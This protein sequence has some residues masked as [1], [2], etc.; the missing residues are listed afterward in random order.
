MSVAE[1][2]SQFEEDHTHYHG[3]DKALDHISVRDALEAFLKEISPVG[4]EKVKLSESLG[5]VLSEDLR[6][7]FDIPVFDRST[8]DGYALKIKKDQI[9]SGFKFRVAGE[10]RIGKRA[11][12]Q[13]KEGEAVRVATGSF[14]PLGANAVVMKEYAEV[15]EN[16]LA[17]EV[18][19]EVSLGE[20]I[21]QA[22]ED[23]RK[24]SLVLSQETRI[25]PHHVALLALVGKQKVSV[26]RCPRI[27]FFSTGD[28][29]VDIN[30]STKSSK[31]K[32]RDVNRPFIESM[33]KELGA[34]PVDLGITKD[35]FNSIRKKL[36]RGLASDAL[37]LS[38]GSSVGEKDYTAKALD[39]IRGVETLV[40]GV[41]M[42]P[43]SPTGL[44]FFKGKPFVML[45]GFP[46]S[47]IV[48]FF[49]FARPAILKLTGSSK[50][51]PQMLNAKLENDYSGKEGLTHFLRLK[52]EERNGDYTAT[53]IKP[54]EAQ[55]SS[56]L[57][58]ANGIG[59]LDPS[60][61]AVRAGDTIQVFLV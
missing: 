43:S 28:E 6:S 21:L 60:K 57:R 19:R 50:V 34:S 25:R 49:V 61:T 33:L 23:I 40:H 20:N 47:M 26:H 58:A 39:S 18:K 15:K 11:S 51:F 3:V 38:A 59:L 29:L 41:A 9:I 46:T 53:I 4:T 52:V 22:G 16:G 10:V 48:S 37:V 2:K 44:G 36:V 27:A 42:R 7:S 55:Y 12:L 35:N 31:E 5:R 54:T 13:V 17:L 32:T 24:G 1:H 14:L 8:R 56:W 30:S 45:P